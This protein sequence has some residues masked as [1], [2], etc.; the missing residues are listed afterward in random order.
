MKFNE[1]VEEEMEG[2]KDEERLENEKGRFR[3]ILREI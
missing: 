1:N 2:E 3:G